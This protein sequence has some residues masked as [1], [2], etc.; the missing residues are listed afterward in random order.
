MELS[1]SG[2]HQPIVTKSSKAYVTRSVAQNKF[3]S[4]SFPR[5]WLF[6]HQNPLKAECEAQCSRRYGKKYVL[7]VS[8]GLSL[9]PACP[10]PLSIFK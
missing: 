4:C 10:I 9:H 2:S 7:T 6:S 5:A 8:S 1:C 3:L